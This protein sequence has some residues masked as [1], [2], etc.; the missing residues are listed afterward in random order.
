[1]PEMLAALFATLLEG[2]V[3]PTRRDSAW[4]ADV[5]QLQQTISH[6][7][8]LSPGLAALLD[9]PDW[10]TEIWADALAQAA[11]ETGCATLPDSCPWRIEDVLMARG[12]PN[13]TR[14]PL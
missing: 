5:A 4:E 8:A 7:L 13:C 1:M 10:R 12:L 11:D 2:Y 14:L 3:Q 9:D 6:Q